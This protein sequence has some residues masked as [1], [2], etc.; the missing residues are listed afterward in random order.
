MRRVAAVGRGRNGAEDG[1]GWSVVASSDSLMQALERTMSAKRAYVLGGAES[2]WACEMMS[3]R[4]SREED[5][6][7]VRAC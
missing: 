5:G 6:C 2:C 1:E 3:Q 4:E 7:Q